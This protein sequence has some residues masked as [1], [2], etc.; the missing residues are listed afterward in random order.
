ME[1]A[2]SVATQAI[3]ETLS[4]AGQLRPGDMH[5]LAEAGFRSIINNRSDFEGGTEQ[6]TSAELE[7]AARAAGLA[8]GHLPVPPAGHTEHQA[9]AMQQLVRQLPHPVV[10]FCRTGRRSA[11]L[12]SMGQA[13][14]GQR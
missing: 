3:D 7:Q 14:G 11:A 1:H 5:A 10:A 9:R 2:T 8:Y 6:P 13:L 4:I 12:Y